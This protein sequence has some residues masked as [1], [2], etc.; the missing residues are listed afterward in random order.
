MCAFLID[1]K[2]TIHMYKKERERKRERK[3]LISTW[4]KRAAGEIM[5]PKQRSSLHGSNIPRT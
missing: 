1:H 3:K 5:R 2:W 4:P